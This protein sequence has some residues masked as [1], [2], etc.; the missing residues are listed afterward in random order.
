MEEFEFG[1]NILLANS[2]E[3]TLHHSNQ[4]NNNT[5]S[6][7]NRKNGNN[8]GNLNN[9]NNKNKNANPIE[10]SN[11]MFFLDWSSLV[12]SNGTSTPL[13]E[14]TS[15]SLISRMSWLKNLI[16]ATIFNVEQSSFQEGWKLP[17]QV[18]ILHQILT[19]DSHVFKLATHTN[20]TNGMVVQLPYSVKQELYVRTSSEVKVQG[21]KILRL[22][23]DVSSSFFDTESSMFDEILHF[24]LHHYMTH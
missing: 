15:L 19:L 3:R 10:E 24:T 21:L 1:F 17:S 8:K 14:A 16:Q 11:Q 7:D 2:D 13:T 23:L 6:S 22:F 9:N 12:Q 4:S 18:R 20:S 5:N